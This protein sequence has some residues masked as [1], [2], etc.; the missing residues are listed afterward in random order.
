MLTSSIVTKLYHWISAWLYN[1]NYQIA[2][3]SIE[4]T[5]KI[6]A[7]TSTM[8]ASNAR[9]NPFKFTREEWPEDTETA[10][11]KITAEAGAVGFHNKMKVLL[12]G[13]ESP[14]LFI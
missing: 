2:Q 1:S 13:T 5:T 8:T 11:M 6:T 7:S 14:K 9:L 4:T 3:Q 12:H 10:K